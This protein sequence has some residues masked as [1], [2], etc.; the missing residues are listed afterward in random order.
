MDALG[1][2]LIVEL[3]EC[4]AEI[5][6]DVV[7]IKKIVMEA[8]NISGAEII[9]PVFHNFN[10]HG[11]S[12]VVVIAESHVSIHTW[13]EHRYC[14]LDIFTCGDVID[15]DKAL[16]YLRK[17]LQAQNIYVKKIKRGIIA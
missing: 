14:A 4:D 17:E 8:V 16:S 12:G 9:E 15:N 2:H 1:I 10:P 5:I 11:V 13:P 3:Y 6:K 7:C